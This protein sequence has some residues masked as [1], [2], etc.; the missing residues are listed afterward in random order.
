MVE[1][2]SSR[3]ELDL[4]GLGEE[5]A[6][7]WRE[8]P[9]G[10]VVWL[11]GELGAGKTALVQ[12]V[13]EAAHAEHARSPTFALVHEYASPEGR[14]AHVDCYRLRRP[15][16]ARDLDLGTLARRSRLM[17]IEWPERA[18]S[19]APAPDRHLRLAHTTRD[20]HRVLEDVK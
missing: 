10:A 4:A 6:R 1:A 20:D 5:G 12:A 18:G 7:L 15:E 3:R 2:V 13:T 9:R 16:E 19:A 8:L 14:I 11:S 17:F